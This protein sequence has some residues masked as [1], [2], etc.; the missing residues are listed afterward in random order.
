MSNPVKEFVMNVCGDTSGILSPK[1]S[2]PPRYN[3][4]EPPLIAR[5]VSGGQE[6]LALHA[7][8]RKGGLTWENHYRASPSRDGRLNGSKE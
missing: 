2:P 6:E 7:N 8:I 3:S 1:N 4:D 5:Y